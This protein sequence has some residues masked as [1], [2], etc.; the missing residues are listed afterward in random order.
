V[1]LDKTATAKAGKPVWIARVSLGVIDG[2]ARPAQ[3][4][5]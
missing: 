3:G 4:P 5:G 1:S 2:Q